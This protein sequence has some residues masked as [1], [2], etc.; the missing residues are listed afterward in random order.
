MP[1]LCKDFA[2]QSI[3]KRRFATPWV[4]QAVSKR[5]NHRNTMIERD[6]PTF[7]P[8][9]LFRG[10]HAQTV[11]GVVFPGSLPEYRASQL[12]VP[13]ADG[14]QIVLHDDCP[15]N[16]RGGQRTALLIHGLGGCHQSPYMRR[17]AAKLSQAGVRSFRMDLRGCGA[18]LEL[19]RL[20]YHS[21]RS[22]DAAA[23]LRFIAQLCPDSPTTLV[24][25]SLG[26]NIVLK[27]LGEC[28]GNPPGNLDSAMA[29]SPPI[30]LMASSDWLSRRLNRF[31][32]RY[33]ARLLW[34]R[35]HEWRQRVPQAAMVEF[36]RRPRR[37]VELDDVY[38]A[39]V[40]GFGS[41][42]NYYRQ[43]SSAPIVPAIRLP[44]LILASHDDPLVPGHAYSQVALPACVQLQMSAG[45]GHLGFI[46]A[47]S[48]D[49]DRRW[50]DWRVVDWV[51]AQ[52]ERPA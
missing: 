42:Q 13:L 34:R 3:Q 23:A 32:D 52:G 46:A 4:V 41:A 22:E 2:R 44:T 33:F 17:I 25:F 39:Q 45:G 15:S 6:Y 16:W 28:G 11:G 47:R 20:P 9:P 31:Y 49:P 10:A 38:T 30:D 27:L 51:V 29:V 1:G 40:C 24:G 50:M 7:R 5:G 43:C 26:G 21:G 48:S 14:D 35:L 36:T 18:G 37:L 12:R 19:A 8:H